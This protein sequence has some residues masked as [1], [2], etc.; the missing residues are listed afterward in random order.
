MDNAS[1]AANPA[2][3]F[4]Q[5]PEH[6]VHVEGFDGTVTVHADHVQIA[7]SDKAI[8]LTETNHAPVYYLPIED[9]DQS[10]LRRSE[11]VT[12]CPFKGKAA[13]WNVV[14]GE[15]EIDNAVW[16][17]EMPYDEMLELAG[18]MAFYTSKVTVTAEPA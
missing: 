9:V 15:H 16:A 12:R 13:H 2:P 18:M 1:L 11:R 7:R 6:V 5:H 3:G 8:L 17:Y 4:V 10:V 14:I